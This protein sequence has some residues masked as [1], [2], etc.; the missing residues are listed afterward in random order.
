MSHPFLSLTLY[1]LTIIIPPIVASELASSV[2]ITLVSP[3]PVSTLDPTY[4]S[5]NIDPSCNR[6]FHQTNFSNPNL[7]AAAHA[8]SPSRLRF[9]GSGTDNLVYGLTPGSPECASVPPVTDCSY[10][11]PGCLNS[12]HWDNLYEFGKAAQVDFIFSVSFNLD[13]ACKVGPSYVWNSS[14]AENLLT[15]LVANGQTDIWGFEHGNEINN[16]GPGTSCNLSATSQGGMTVK[17]WSLVRPYM[18]NVRLIGPDSGGYNP[19]QWLNDFLPAVTSVPL[20]A[21]THHVY[22]GVNRQTFNSVE[23][24]DNSLAEIAWYTNVSRTLAPKAEYWA[25]ENGPTGGGNDGTCG[26]DTVCGLFASTLWYADDMSVRAKHGFSNYQRHDFFG[27]AYGLT[28]SVTGVMALGPNDPLVIRP[29]FWI[30]FLWKRTLGTNVLNVT[31]TS[32]LIRSY[33]YSG[34]PPSQFAATQCINSPIQLLLINLDNST[35]GTPITL[36]PVGSSTQFAAWTLS[37]AQNQPDGPFTKL[38]AINNVP[39]VVTVDVSQG[40][41]NKYLSGITQAP[42]IGTVTEGITISPLSTT[43]ICYM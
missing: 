24:L 25:G 42:I 34:L 8:L 37:A 22:N 39:V 10:T 7:A 41:P 28:N 27:G 4:A 19:L 21:V 16:A 18:P 36:P 3:N 13:E 1:L 14:N 6:G 38:S 17:W 32:P 23:Q 35:S 2:V 30:N 11:T 20:H 33:A 31:S 12:T 5:W 15:Y 9:G 43:F 26:S 29:D 40:D